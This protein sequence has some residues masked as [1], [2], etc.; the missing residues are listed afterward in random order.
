MEWVKH[1][2]P[3]SMIIYF[4]FAG[5][6]KSFSS[7]LP[8]MNSFIFRLLQCRE[9][10]SGS[11]AMSNC[12]ELT[13]SISFACKYS[14]HNWNWTCILK[15]MNSFKQNSWPYLFVVL[16]VCLVVWFLL[17]LI[18]TIYLPDPGLKSGLMAGQFG[19]LIDF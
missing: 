12:F 8:S 9:A 17:M 14:Y 3:A 10:A 18:I 2:P 19:M 13:W 6:F 1:S 16:F 15:L 5:R 7:V 4:V 11:R